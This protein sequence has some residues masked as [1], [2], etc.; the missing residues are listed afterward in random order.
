[1]EKP[2]VETKIAV[3][4]ATING[5][6]YWADSKEGMDS[7]IKALVPEGFRSLSHVP[8]HP[9]LGEFKGMGDVDD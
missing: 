6:T 7:L 1:M 2:E 3:Y 9:V 8:H 4:S 5:H